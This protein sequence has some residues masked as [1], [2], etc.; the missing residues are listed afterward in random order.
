M[1]PMS[2]A[3]YGLAALLWISIGLCMRAVVLNATHGTPLLN[4]DQ[5]ASEFLTYYAHPVLAGVVFAGLFAA[6]M[7][8]ADSFLNIGSAAI[9]HDLPQAFG[10]RPLKYELRW[11]RIATV[12]IAV[13]AGLLAYYAG[14]MVAMLG[15]MGW[16][17]FAI[18]IVPIVAI[19]FNWKRA[20][21][22][23]VNTAVISGLVCYAGLYLTD[24]RL[25]YNFHQGAFSMLITL[26][27]FFMV[28]LVTPANRLDKDIDAVMDL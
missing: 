4:A 21:R 22:I 20:N 3:G 16:S 15:V 17:I 12:V 9:V 25:P 5:A 8:T 2:V 27:I 13:G 26:T 6:I 10:M 24:I 19:G 18:A 1:L 28:A 14:E 7:S 23:A 11:A